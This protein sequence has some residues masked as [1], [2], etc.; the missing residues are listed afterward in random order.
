MTGAILQRKH[1]RRVQR[2]EFTVDIETWACMGNLSQKSDHD[3]P[4]SSADQPTIPHYLSVTCLVL[5]TTGRCQPHHW[6]PASHHKKTFLDQ[7]VAKLRLLGKLAAVAPK[8][9]VNIFLKS[10]TSYLM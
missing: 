3:F 4:S 2:G 9:L 1:Q 10:F 5:S 6:P 8:L 7:C